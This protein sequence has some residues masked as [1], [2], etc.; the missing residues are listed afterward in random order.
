M[1]A[2]LSNPNTNFYTK[3]N[4]AVRLIILH[5]TAGLED[6]DMVGADH[7]AEGTNSYG[8][9]T[10]RA[11][12]WHSCIDS[13]SIAPALPDEYT[14]FHCV[15]YNSPSLG[16]EISNKD[17]R[18]DNKPEPWTAAT[19]LNAARVC[20]DWERK[21][22]IP[23]VLRSKAE[24][25][26][27]ARGYSYH[28]FLDPDRRR[29]PGVT[30]PWDYFVSLLESLEAGTAPPAAPPT[31]TPWRP[32]GD[33]LLR[34][35]VYGPRTKQ[36]QSRLNIR[37]DSYFGDDT[38][39]AVLAYQKHFGLSADGIVGPETWGHMFAAPPPAPNQIAVDGDFGPGTIRALQSSL[40]STGANP[41]LAVDGDFGPTS[42][43]ALQARLN[44]VQGP[45]GVDGNVGPQTIRALQR[46]VGSGVDGNWGEKTTRA[47][48]QKLNSG[49]F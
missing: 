11:A 36:L 5:V 47:L 49:T 41:R 6:L 21:Y 7:S 29:D 20:L 28:M 45:V 30:F 22:S 23:R 32:E 3:R 24:V 4:N 27:G 9:T 1:Y 43:R 38:E 34:K 44:H 8:A 18:W 37:A 35:Y 26:A 16:L 10:S 17:A 39:V 13:D 14:A 46:H 15:N 40:N 48:Q 12:S 31:E 19:L 25:D 42:R 33:G 2:L